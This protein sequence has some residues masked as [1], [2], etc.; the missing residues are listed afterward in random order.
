MVA[1]LFQFGVGVLPVLIIVTALASHRIENVLLILVPAISLLFITVG[2]GLAVS[3]LF[4]YFRDLPYIYELVVFICWMMSPIFYPEEIVPDRLRP[5]IQL[6]PIAAITNDMR[7]IAFNQSHI[8]LHVLALTLLG[9]L[10]TAAAGALVFKL[11]Q[12]HAMDL[13]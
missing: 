1:N 13:L 7:Q 2:A 5:Y 11:L 9:S 4:V 3:A 8:H 6:N 10:I 12:K